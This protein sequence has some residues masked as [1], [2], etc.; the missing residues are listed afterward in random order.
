MA[1]SL[2]SLLRGAQITISAS[3]RQVATH[4]AKL[5]LGT[6]VVSQNLDIAIPENKILV[7]FFRFKILSV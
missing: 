6:P 4:H 1:L 2:R 5:P 3:A 7:S